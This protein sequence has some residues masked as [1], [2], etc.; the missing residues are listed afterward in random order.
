MTDQERVPDEDRAADGATE[1]DKVG[2]QADDGQEVLIDTV[3]A[4]DEDSPE[5]AAG[6]DPAGE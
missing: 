5:P 1:A 2:E 3:T 4:G 6:Q